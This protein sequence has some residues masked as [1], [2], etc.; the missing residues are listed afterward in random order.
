MPGMI[1]KIIS[2]ALAVSSG[3]VGQ[4]AQ[5]Q[6]VAKIQCASSVHAIIARGQGPGDDLNVMVKV[7]NLILDQI[8][9]STSVGLP[10]AHDAE[11]KFTAVHDGALLMQSYVTEYLNVCPESKIALIGYSLGAVTMMEAVC[12]TSSLLLIPTQPFDASLNKTS[13]NTLQDTSTGNFGL[14]THLVIAAIAYGDET[15]VPLQPWDVGDCTVGL[16][17]REPNDITERAIANTLYQIKIF[18]RLLPITCE[19]FASSLQSYCDYGDD[20]CCAVLPADDNAAHHG[21]VDKYSQDVVNFIEGRLNGS[22]V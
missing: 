15:F 2:L 9:G 13:T 10:Y 22:I 4:R 3:L 17:S 12:G 14:K 6:A 1:S 5:A 18:P 21:Y 8:P 7:Q 20:Q 11:D 16:R 19:P